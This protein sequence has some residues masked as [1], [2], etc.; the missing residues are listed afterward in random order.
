MEP[1]RL[2]KGSLLLPVDD[3]TDDQPAGH[4]K[5]HDWCIYARDD[6]VRKAEQEPDNNAGQPA[7]ELKRCVRDE[8]TDGEPVYK[9]TCDCNVPVRQI[10][11]YH[12]N[13]INDPEN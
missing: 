7:G 3:Q 10:H 1:S 4:S 5:T 12:W 8:K 13:D 9:R 6:S 2:L 11:K